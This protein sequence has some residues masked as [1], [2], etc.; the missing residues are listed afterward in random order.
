ME[1]GSAKV[2]VLIRGSLDDVLVEDLK[3][4]VAGSLGVWL[5]G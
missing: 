1:G 5:E 4:I 2:K 3:D